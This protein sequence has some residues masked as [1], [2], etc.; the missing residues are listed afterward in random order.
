M[1]CSQ[2]WASELSGVPAWMKSS[3]T[4]RSSSSGCGV[5][6]GAAGA[7]ILSSGDLSCASGDLSCASGDLSCASA[8]VPGCGLPASE[9]EE[10]S[11]SRVSSEVGEPMAGEPVASTGESVAVGLLVMSSVREAGYGGL[12]A[13]SAGEV[14]QP[15]LAGVA[16]LGL[17]TGQQGFEI[18]AGGKRVDQAR[19]DDDHQL[20]LFLRVVEVLEEGAQDGQIAQHRHLADVGGGGTADQPADD[21]A[22]AIGQLHR[23]VGAARADGDRKSTRLNS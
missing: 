15:D 12:G 20:G 7:G 10:R 6:R 13:H 16:L 2:A 22:L 17:R 4:C 11:P 9:A 19:G 21:E 14:G 5:G 3:S 23:G 1:C 18:G 8:S